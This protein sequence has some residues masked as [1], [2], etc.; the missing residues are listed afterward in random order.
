MKTTYYHNCIDC[1]GHKSPD[2][3]DHDFLQR[4]E[5]LESLVEALSTYYNNTEEALHDHITHLYELNTNTLNTLDK[6]LTDTTSRLVALKDEHNYRLETQLRRIEQ[7][8]IA[9]DG[10]H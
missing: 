10:V 5:H 3:N 7:L 4:L 8:E 1:K 6:R 2:T 9:L